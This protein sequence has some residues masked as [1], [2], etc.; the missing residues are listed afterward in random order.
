MELRRIGKHGDIGLINVFGKGLEVAIP[1]E[2][3]VFVFFLPSFDYQ[4]TDVAGQMP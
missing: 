3:K 4:H 2:Q 1:S